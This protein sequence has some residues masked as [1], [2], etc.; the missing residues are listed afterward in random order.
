M[1]G[2]RVEKLKKAD[3][4]KETFLTLIDNLYTKKY[5]QIQFAQGN[6]V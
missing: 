2:S 4:A 1:L 5:V 6:C 3:V